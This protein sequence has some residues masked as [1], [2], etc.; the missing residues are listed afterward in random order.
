MSIR[1]LLVEDDRDL[2]ESLA[3]YLSKMGIDVKTAESIE[4][5]DLQEPLNVDIIL[6]DINLPGENGMIA[7]TRFR[8]QSSAGIIMLTARSAVEDRIMGLSIGADSYLIKPVDPR[9]LEAAI[10]SLYRRLTSPPLLPS[11]T[12]ILYA[13]NGD[14]AHWVF[15]NSKWSLCPPNAQPL[16][17]SAMEYHFV[18][19]LVQNAGEAVSRERIL[20]GLGKYSG[21]A[22]ARSL[23]T[24]LSR[25]RRKVEIVSPETPLPIRSVRGI[26]YVFAESVEVIGK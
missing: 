17:L 18:S 6:L 21:D 26:G 4:S 23:D 25:L 22:E 9:E 16:V 15:D 12:G 19:L 1:V 13:A 7:A 10:R 14:G 24:L 2:S 11:Q 5:L 8:Q 20:S 3:R